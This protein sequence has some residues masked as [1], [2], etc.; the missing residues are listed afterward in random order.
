MTPEI[1]T[2]LGQ[3]FTVP[4]LF[5]ILAVAFVT[6]AVYAYALQSH[7]QVMQQSSY[8]ARAFIRVAV[9]GKTRA[10]DRL[11]LVTTLGFLTF[12]LFNFAFSFL[13]HNA[14]SFIGF[15]PLLGF[16]VWFITLE[17]KR[18]KKVPLKNTPRLIRLKVLTTGITFALTFGL[19]V[20]G[21][22]VAYVAKDGSVSVGRYLPVA[23]LPYLLPFVVCLANT[24]LLPVEKLLARKY[25]IRAKQTI[26]QSK[27]VVVG[28]TGSYGKTSV[29]NALA[30]M[31]GKKFRVLATPASYNTPLGISRAVEGGMDGVQIFIAEMGARKVGDIAELCAMTHPSIGVVTAVG[32]QHLQSFGCEENVRKAKGE[33]P[34]SLPK[35]GFAVFGE[36][37]GCYAL[38]QACGVKKAFAPKIKNVQVGAERTTFTLALTSGDVECSTTLLG[39]HNLQNL[40]L[41]AV[42]CEYFGME[43]WEIAAGIAA[44][45][46]PEH[47]LQRI[48]GANG[49]IIDDSY[50]S[51][52]VGARCAIDA[53]MQ[54]DGRKIVVT[55]GFVELGKEEEKENHALGKALVVCDKV[56]AVGLHRSKPLVRGL[57]EAGYDKSNIVVVASLEEA[58]EKLQ[59][60]AKNGDVTLFLNDLPDAYEE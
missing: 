9:T 53:L 22:A 25:I 20:A 17:S 38:Y 46:A 60:D 1:I 33:L 29:K 41:A 3:L 24:L 30:V 43:E 44:V 31:L 48:Q 54:F 18:I 6:A 11:R 19:A 8:R 5:E 4:Y 10:K 50:N 16:F 51:N 36:D 59:K 57:L 39:C 42:V 35:N 37:E 12:L 26:K 56:Y 14:V 52:P 21:N 23:L 40:A 32:K 27:A 34:Q 13:N 45:S 2:S 15:I 28:V 49:V 58:K 55:P 7:F 47:R